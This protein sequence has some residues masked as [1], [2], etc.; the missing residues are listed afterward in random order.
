MLIRCVI[1]LN[2]IVSFTINEGEIEITYNA[3]VVTYTFE[4]NDSMRFKNQKNYLFIYE[5]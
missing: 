1:N 3:G 2:N 4:N 5:K